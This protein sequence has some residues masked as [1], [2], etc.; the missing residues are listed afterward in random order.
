MDERE[1]QR[2]KDESIIQDLKSGKTALNN[3]INNNQL[4]QM[5]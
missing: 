2:F 5:V 1:S 3:G 4:K